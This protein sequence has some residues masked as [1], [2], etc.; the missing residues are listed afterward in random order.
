MSSYDQSYYYDQ[1]VYGYAVYPQYYQSPP[2]PVYYSHYHTPVYPAPYQIPEYNNLPENIQPKITTNNEEIVKQ[3]KMVCEAS[4]SNAGLSKEPYLVRQLARSTKG[5]ISIKLI[6]SMKKIRK[7]TRKASC[8][9]TLQVVSEALSASD[10]FE[11]SEDGHKVRRVIELPESLKQPK[12]IA[13]ILAICISEEE[14][15]IDRLSAIFKEFGSIQQMRVV[16]PERTLPP[17]L[18]GY[19]TQVPELGKEMCAIIEYDSEE[20]A[21]NACRHFQMDVLEHNSMRVALLG[22]R[23][24]RNLYGSVR[25]SNGS[26]QSSV[27]SSLDVSLEECVI[28]DTT[29]TDSGIFNSRQNVL[30]QSPSRVRVLS[31]SSESNTPRSDDESV[32]NSPEIQT[33]ENFDFC[34]E[35]KMRRRNSEK[36]NNDSSEES[37]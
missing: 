4:F 15:E 1:G 17:Y 35:L 9:S 3:V 13:T 27:I 25:R 26:C 11:V 20:A 6:A 36:N 24:K 31:G 34:E 22:P 14:A 28:T 37:N 29:D 21:M 23:I 32:P 5:F 10:M 18:Q 16:R 12:I 33:T 8:N 2:P 7:V 19:A 30:D